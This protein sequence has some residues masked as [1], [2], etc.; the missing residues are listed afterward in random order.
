MGSIS[1]SFSK[2]SRLSLSMLQI[3]TPQSRRQRGASIVEYV[4]LLALIA[5]VGLT[6]YRSIG[7]KMRD[8]AYTN[9]ADG[10]NGTYDG[11]SSGQGGCPDTGGCG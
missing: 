2:R 4:L 9:I 5:L 11:S 8:G 6:A 3:F 1:L 10:M 7:T